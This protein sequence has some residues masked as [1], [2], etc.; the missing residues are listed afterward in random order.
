MK[1]KV[2]VAV[3]VEDHERLRRSLSRALEAWAEKV[4]AT[5]NVTEALRLV[6]DERPQ[7]VVTDVRLPDGSG[8]EVARAASRSTPMPAVV[9]LS[10]EATADEAFRLAEFGVRG[11]LN[12]PVQL[13]ELNS[14]IGKALGEAP[15]LDAGLRN[16][17]GKVD[18]LDFETNVRRTLIDEAMAKAGGN[19]ARAAELLAVSRQLLQHMLR[20]R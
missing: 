20:K 19:K 10:G 3:L 6:A 7:L 13:D 18:L 15:A 12:K 1:T 2:A 11:Y 17:V 8:L 5:D 16:A 14:A 9:A 4:H